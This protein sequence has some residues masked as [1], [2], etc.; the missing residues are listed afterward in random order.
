MCPD[1]T[2]G[3]VTLTILGG[4]RDGAVGAQLIS[5]PAHEALVRPSARPP[6]RP[7][8][9]PPYHPANVSFTLS[10]TERIRDRDLGSGL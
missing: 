8:A 7:S 3:G 1:A 2:W 6:V 5:S 10:A 4:E 9:R